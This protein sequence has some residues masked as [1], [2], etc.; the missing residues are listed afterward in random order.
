[1]EFL[2]DWLGFIF[3]GLP[4]MVW[5]YFGAFWYITI[6]FGIWYVYYG[7]ECAL[8][9]GTLGRNPLLMPFQCFWEE[10]LW[11]LPGGM[12]RKIIYLKENV[13]GEEGSGCIVGMGFFGKSWDFEEVRQKNFYKACARDVLSG[14]FH[15][16]IVVVAAPLL[17][18]ASLLLFVMF[19]AAISLIGGLVG[20]FRTIFGLE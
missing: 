20:F 1:M 16:W 7:F 10:L 17:W 12:R 4:V 2:T 19:V 8:N 14:S 18:P 6:A 5:E 13:I 3:L 9:G 15:F 11:N